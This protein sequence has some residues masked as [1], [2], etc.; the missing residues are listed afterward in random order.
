MKL[1]PGMVAEYK[2]RHDKVWPDLAALLKA[3]GIYDYNIFYDPESCV[4]FASLKQS[5]A[6]GKDGLQ[7]HPIIREW[8]EYMADIMETNPDNSPVVQV[9]QEVFHLD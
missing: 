6:L 5:N 4:L 8:W 1:N 3:N 7:D 2:E 9:L